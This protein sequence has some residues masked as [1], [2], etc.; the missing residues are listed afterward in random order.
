MAVFVLLL[1]M[2]FARPG[3]LMRLIRR[4]IA[5]STQ[6]VLRWWG[7]LL[8]PEERPERSKTDDAD[9]SLALDLEWQQI[10][11]PISATLKGKPE[12]GED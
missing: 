4:C 8:S 9:D 6:G 2:T 10:M 11:G 3:E 7:L 5:P 12:Q 1:V